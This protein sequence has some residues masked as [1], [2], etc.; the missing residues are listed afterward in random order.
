MKN[1]LY[2][3]AIIF[4]YHISFCRGQYTLNQT[5]Y[6]LVQ[7]GPNAGPWANFGL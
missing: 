3:L 1:A 4:P 5:L 2:L 6:D 7:H